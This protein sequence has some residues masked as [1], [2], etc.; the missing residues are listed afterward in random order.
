[1][2]Q[3]VAAAL[4]VAG[5]CFIDA[6]QAQERAVALRGGTVI[7]VEGAPIPNGTV[8]MRGGKLVAVGANVPIPPGA[9]VVDVRGK[10]ILPGLVDAMTSL[11]LGASDLNEPSDPIAPQLRVFEAYNPFGAFGGGKP[12]PLVNHE[13]LGGG[14]TTMYIA[15]A[16]GALIGGQGAVVKTAGATLAALVVREPASMDMTLGEPPK[17]AA[18]QRQRDPATRMA[19][20]AMIRQALIRAQEYDR[21]K[22]ANPSLPRDLGMEA[23]GRLLKREFPARIQATSA[24]DI[25]S[26][27]ALAREF[28]FDLVLDG[29]A[30]APQY[31]DTLAA[32]R[33]PVVLG[34]VSHQFVSNEEIPDRSDYPPVDESTAARLLKGGVKTAIASFSRAF[35]TLA[36][37]G[38]SKWL[39]ID[40]A[41]A[42]GFGLSEGE[43]IRAVTL[44]PAEIL[45]V[46]DRVGSLKAGKDA[47]V[48][49]LDGPPL[50]VRSWVTR[51]YINGELV[52]QR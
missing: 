16:D 46:A 33:I 42:A 18:R 6:A 4:A 36:P 23:L 15:P 43:V 29:A 32:R 49:V 21:N 10:Y 38:S 20:V 31:L 40:A 19:E 17:S 39:L 25:R 41:V 34:Q 51:A 12:G 1:M 24:V 11:G 28:G 8:V 26:A 3:T 5:T 14:V 45:G 13:V 27:L 47:D 9:E 37:A 50:S 35:G 30:S 52:H 2:L 22:A 44:T 7:P 48:I